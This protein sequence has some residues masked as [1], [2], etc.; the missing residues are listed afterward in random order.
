[1]KTAL[2]ALVLVSTPSF[3][4]DRSLGA[5]FKRSQDRGFQNHITNSSKEYLQ[6]Q[7]QH[8]AEMEPLM[9]QEAAAKNYHDSFAFKTEVKGYRLRNFD[10]YG[11]YT[12]NWYVDSYLVSSHS[13]CHLEEWSYPRVPNLRECAPGEDPSP[14]GGTSVECKTVHRS[15]VCGPKTFAGR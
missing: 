2:L 11:H 14:H 8:S 5:Q 1:L 3:A 10:G 13:I 6:R 12:T 15:T 7:K 4:T 9:R